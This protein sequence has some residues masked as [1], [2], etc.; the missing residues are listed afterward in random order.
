MF[1]SVPVGDAIFMKWILHDWSDDHCL[2]LLKNCYKAL[3]EDGKV[4]VVDAILPMKTDASSS[5]ISTSQCDL[6]MMT[7]DPG[8][9]ERSEVEFLALA[10]GAGFTGIKLYCFVCNFWVMEFHK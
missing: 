8:G 1:E 7:Q 9:K 4:I 5:V 2:K 10:K 6:I 3:P